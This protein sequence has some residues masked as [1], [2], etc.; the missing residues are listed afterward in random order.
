MSFILQEETQEFLIA[1]QDIYSDLKATALLASTSVKYKVIDWKK[2]YDLNT[3][4]SDYF[5]S[6][7]NSR[8]KCTQISLE[9]SKN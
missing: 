2:Q 6:Q 9:S 1:I 5:N 7:A 8:K 4:G 3:Y